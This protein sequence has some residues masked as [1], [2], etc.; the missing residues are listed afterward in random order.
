MSTYDTAPDL[1]TDRP[2]DD[3]LRYY[4]LRVTTPHSHWSR[5]VEVL[6]KYSKRFLAGLHYP[7]D[8]LEHD[9]K[10]EHEHFHFVFLDCLDAKT[11]DAMKKALKKE[12]GRGGN[13]FFAGNNR[14]NHVYKAIQYMRHQPDVEFKHW[15]SGWTAI[16]DASP[17]WE[18]RASKKAK[19]APKE[20]ASFPTVTT[21]NVV[22]Q[23]LRWKKQHD[24]KTT[25][26]AVV[27]EHMTRMGNWQP[28]PD[29]MRRGLDPMHFKMFEFHAKD[30]EGHVPNW[31]D[32]RFV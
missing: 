32:P 9:V 25:D 30:K 31:W 5:L 20:K 10:D 16:I 27:C 15:G 11:Q 1:P 22:K 8:D 12:F 2:T 23:A 29:V 26:L 6:R 24:L 21:Y 17:E 3:L 14:D 13:G 18:D 4:A 19:L 28:G 7:H